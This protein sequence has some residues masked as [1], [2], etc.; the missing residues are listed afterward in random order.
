MAAKPLPSAIDR[1]WYLEE[2]QTPKP[3]QTKANQE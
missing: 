3:K 1:S 2:N